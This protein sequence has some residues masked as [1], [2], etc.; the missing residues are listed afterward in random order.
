MAKRRTE[1]G[2]FKEEAKDETSAQ[3]RVIIL[4]IYSHKNTYNTQKSGRKSMGIK[5]DRKDN[6]RA[7]MYWSHLQWETVMGVSPLLL[8]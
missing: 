8:L 1:I 2:N 3:G 4:L 7:W 6:S 5:V